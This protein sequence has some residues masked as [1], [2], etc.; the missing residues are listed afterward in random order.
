MDGLGFDAPVNILPSIFQGF[1]LLLVTASSLALAAP[2]YPK[3][4][5][6]SPGISY[7][8]VQHKKVEQASQNIQPIKKCLETTPSQS[9]VPYLDILCHFKGAPSDALQLRLGCGRP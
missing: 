4:A 2:N 8:P 3:E 5:P 9:F 6:S 1:L 7:E